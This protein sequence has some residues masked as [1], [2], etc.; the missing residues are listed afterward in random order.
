[1]NG[2]YFAKIVCG[3]AGIR[4]EGRELVD[5]DREFAD[6]KSFWDDNASRESFNVLAAAFVL[7]R[8]HHELPGGEGY[9]LRA[10]LAILEAW[11]RLWSPRGVQGDADMSPARD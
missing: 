11:T 1:M 2:V 10:I 7:G 5:R 9:H 8:A 3:Y 6:R 4:N